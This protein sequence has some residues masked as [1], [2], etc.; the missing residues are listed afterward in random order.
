MSEVF[1]TEGPEGPTITLL[2]PSDVVPGIAPQAIDYDWALRQIE[3]IQS[4][5][6]ELGPCVI[7]VGGLF[8]LYQSVE[9]RV[10][11]PDAQMMWD[12]LNSNFLKGTRVRWF[13]LPQQQPLNP[14]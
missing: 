5:L 13:V 3:R 9:V 10:Q 14:S 7:R 11:T 4:K 1:V 8:N 2:P 6:E 12:Y